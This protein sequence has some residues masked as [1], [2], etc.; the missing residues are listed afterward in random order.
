[1]LQGLPFSEQVQIQIQEVYK[2]RGTTNY[3]S[4]AEKMQ[5][6]GRW[7]YEDDQAINPTAGPSRT[8]F[9]W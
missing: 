2:Y 7:K 3:K 8:H 9:A 1:M 4:N 5:K 6:I